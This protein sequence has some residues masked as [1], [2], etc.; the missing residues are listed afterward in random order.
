MESP[1]VSLP[2]MTCWMV[3]RAVVLTASSLSLGAQVDPLRALVALVGSRARRACCRARRP[4]R[5]GRPTT[6]RSS[7]RA[8]SGSVWT[9]RRSCG[10]PRAPRAARPR[11]RRSSCAPHDVARRGSRRWRRGRPAAVAV[12]SPVC[13]AVAVAGAEALRAERL[14]QRA[15]RGEAVVL[16][17]DDDELDALLHGGHDL[18]GHHQV[19]AVAD[20]H[21]HLA[22]RARP[23]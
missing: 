20:H 8:T 21:E 23:S 3:F 18:L 15:D 19:G 22:V 11:T 14:R 2:A 7:G 9:A 4:R 1:V 12:E 5:R 17:E 6:P 13:V 10:R 16:D